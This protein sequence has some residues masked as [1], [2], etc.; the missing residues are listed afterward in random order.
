[1]V[2]VRVRLV[3]LLR[4]AVGKPVVE[5]DVEDG[6]TLGRVLERL[7]SMYPKLREIVEGLER[8]GLEVVY[9]VNG[10]FTGFDEKVGEG[11][12]VVILP[13]ASGG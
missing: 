13:P 1:M 6:A 4:D 11:D 9:M 8:R 2:R 5:L 7:Y 3:S 12:E 10:R